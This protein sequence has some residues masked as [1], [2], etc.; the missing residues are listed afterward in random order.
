LH[1][2]IDLR[3]QA[4]LA[5]ARSVTIGSWFSDCIGASSLARRS[6]IVRVVSHQIEAIST[7]RKIGHS[8]SIKWYQIS[9]LIGEFYRVFFLSYS[10]QKSKTKIISG[11]ILVPATTF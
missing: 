6:R 5:P 2:G 8:A 10:P 7:H 3:D 11:K 1:T 4:D 9:R